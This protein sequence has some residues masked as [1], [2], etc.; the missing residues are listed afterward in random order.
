MVAA[1]FPQ[2]CRLCGAPGAHDL[3]LCAPCA[4]ELPWLGRACVRCALPLPGGT[5][6]AGC[7]RR[8]PP[9]QAAFAALRYA[10][11]A[12]RLVSELKFGRRI[13]HAR[14]LGALGARALAAAPGWQAPAAFVPV[15]LHHARL[16]TRGFDQALEIARELGRR[17][18]VPVWD[19][20]VRPRATTPQSDLPAA[21][22]RRNLRG[23][24]AL[25][26]AP[27]PGTLAVVDDVMTTG[28]TV[29]DLA[30]TLLAGGAAEVIVT[31]I[32]RTP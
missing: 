25:R 7:L 4:D 30:R 17:L 19:G 1:L 16:R 3:A 6:C 8:P 31:V 21:A 18:H 22:R 15:P 27:P 32:A 13:A 26:E 5:L 11:P 2:R 9:Q 23:A 29:Q 24:F 12:D 10:A 14:L 28:A 20:A